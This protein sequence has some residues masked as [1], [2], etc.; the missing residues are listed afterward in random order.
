MMEN[1]LIEVGII[2]S[3][4]REVLGDMNL[5]ANKE[6]HV[7]FLVTCKMRIASVID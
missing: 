6:V 5:L 3:I 2:F 4:I 7:F 1:R